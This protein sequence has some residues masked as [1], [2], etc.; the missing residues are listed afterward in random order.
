MSRQC[1]K[2]KKMTGVAEEQMKGQRRRQHKSES[3]P[4]RM[5]TD[6][7][8]KADSLIIMRMY[9]CLPSRKQPFK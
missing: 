9:E 1:C 4:E 2:L 7:T 5:T 6:S 3:G 8:N